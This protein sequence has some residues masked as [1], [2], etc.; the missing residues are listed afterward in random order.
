M[1][2]VF[3]NTGT[4]EQVIAVKGALKQSLTFATWIVKEYLVMK[5]Q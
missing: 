2:R 1:S 5:K 3:S 4:K